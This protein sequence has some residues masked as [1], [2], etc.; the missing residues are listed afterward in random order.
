VTVEFCILMTLFPLHSS[1]RRGRKRQMTCERE[2]APSEEV[3]CLQN[4]IERGG[5]TRRGCK[6][7]SPAVEHSP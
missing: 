4:C 7:V 5:S 6:P 3:S 2:R 1:L